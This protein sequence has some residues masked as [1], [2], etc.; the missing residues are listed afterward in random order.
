[1][2]ALETNFYFDKYQ[3]CTARQN[4]NSLHALSFLSA[5]AEEDT[6]SIL[7]TSLAGPESQGYSSAPGANSL[8]PSC[9]TSHFNREPLYYRTTPGSS[10][11]DLT[12]LLTHSP[13]APT[14]WRVPVHDPREK[15]GACQLH[16]NKTARSLM[17][18]K[19]QG[20][21]SQLQVE[22]QDDKEIIHPIT[23]ADA[24]TA[25]SFVFLLC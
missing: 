9:S 19:C 12:Q 1:M 5:D 25:F 10:S 11:L 18:M 4:S 22:L 16:L 17:I 21:L 24:K 3:M 7:W 20:F 23:E 8:C 6:A 13:R 14:S 2:W 15:Q